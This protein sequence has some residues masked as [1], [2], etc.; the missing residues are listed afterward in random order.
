MTE[1]LLS[2]LKRSGRVGHAL[3]AG[4]VP[5]AEQLPEGLRRERLDLPELSESQ[6]VRHFVPLFPQKKKEGGGGRSPPPPSPSSTPTHP[7][8]YT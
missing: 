6:V 5:E 1:P 3:P 7:T 2:E 8:I 4:D